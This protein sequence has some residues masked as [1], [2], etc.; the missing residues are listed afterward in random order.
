[1]KLAS[2][3]GWSP[4]AGSASDCR[5]VFSRKSDISAHPTPTD[6]SLV[7]V[8]DRLNS[9]EMSRKIA[10]MPKRNRKR[11]RQASSIRSTKPSIEFS[12]VNMPEDNR[13]KFKAAMLQVATH[14]VT[15]FPETIEVV[16]DQF[17]S[18]DPIEIMTSFATYGLM[19]A[20]IGDTIGHTFIANE[21]QQHHAELLQAILLMVPFEEWGTKPVLPD[22][23]Q[24]IFDTVPQLSNTFLHQRVLA[25]D[26]VQDQHEKAGLFLLERIRFH[27]QAVRN[28]GYFSDVKQLSTELY[29]PLDS[30]FRTQCGFGISELVKVTASLVTECERRASEHFVV[31][32]EVL[33]GRNAEQIVRLYYRHVTDLAGTPEQFIAMMPADTT[34]EGVLSRLMTHL[35]YRLAV[36]SLFRPDEI[37]AL[38]G[39]TPELVETVLRA[40]SL[41]PGELVDAKPEYLFL[42]NPVWT[43][44]GIDLGDRFFVPIPQLVF[45]HIHPLVARIGSGACLERELEDVRSHFL[46]GKVCQALEHALPGATISSNAKWLLEDRQFE[47]DCIAIIDRTVVVAEA[48][49]NHL[50]P[51]GLR[52]APDR[53]KR[54]VQELILDPSIQSARLEK[55][56]AD[57]KSGDVNAVEATRGLGLD[58][59]KVDRVIRLSV[60]L[61]DLSALHSAETE[62]K[63]AGMDS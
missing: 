39:Q 59:S 49:S 34:R 1:M 35:G 56:I 54:H 53:L 38:T 44:P 18:S 45:S 29:E 21:I 20:V 6:L 10:D 25:A 9:S 12:A 13:D 30:R 5:F 11:R 50:T 17:R 51:A 32:Q 63:K 46:E 26:K 19:R 42:S 27:T 16:K 14:S 4:I 52:G 37:S 36:S 7:A 55:L 8:L 31:L 28:W 3:Y 43:A 47:S 2:Q 40:I 48:K 58:V 60:T 33:A 61:D 62:F 57:A 22:V 41:A 23:M 24:T 15:E